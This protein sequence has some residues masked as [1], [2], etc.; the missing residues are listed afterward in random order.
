MQHD[1]AAV[2]ALIIA[3]D[4]VLAAVLSSDLE[5]GGFLP[6]YLGPH[7]PATAELKSVVAQYS[8]GLVVTGLQN[9][10]EAGSVA[11]KVAAVD[12]RLPVVAVGRGYS[13]ASIQE[14]LDAGVSEYLAWPLEPS[15][16][17]ACLDRARASRPS[18][19]VG[20]LYAF[21]PAKAGSGASTLALNAAVALGHIVR[22]LLLADF[23]FTGGTTTM[24]LSS[25]CAP[26]AV[27]ALRCSSTRF[28]LSWREQVACYGEI[29]MLPS[30]PF[31]PEAKPDQGV[32]GRLL[33]DARQR[34]RSICADLSGN[35]EPHSL[36]TIGSASA[37]F[38]VC[39]PD[40]AALVLAREKFRWLQKRIGASAVRL[41]LN[42]HSRRSMSIS[43][44]ED[45]VGTTVDFTFPN[46]FNSVARSVM[47]GAPVPA[48]SD[49]G[50][51]VRIFADRLADRSAATMLPLAAAS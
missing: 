4:P 36:E 42:R 23:D 2:P 8:P 38:L 31:D 22:P 35:F 47:Q 18:S 40:P 7:C 11:R 28:D 32:I 48:N 27:R 51:A 10:T 29:D 1:N 20:A 24:L 12:G 41:L 33:A 14:I 30:G 49:L 15:C 21:V 17:A 34:Y 37:V 44:V 19:T 3:G 16:L 26:Q 50:K 25:S 45:F 5:L 39:T 43:E 13:P 9:A 6:V 46:D